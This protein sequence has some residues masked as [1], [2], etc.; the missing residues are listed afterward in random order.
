MD[1]DAKCIVR[2]T[3]SKNLRDE[4]KTYA[5]E[6]LAEMSLQDFLKMC[7]RQYMNRYAKKPPEP[8]K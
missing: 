8:K 2:I 4:F 6:K 3:M 1:Q 7:A 5:T